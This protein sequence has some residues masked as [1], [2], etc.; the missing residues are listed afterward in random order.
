MGR[1]VDFGTQR[2]GAR[3]TLRNIEMGPQHLVPQRSANAEEA[4]AKPATTRHAIFTTRR[5]VLGGGAMML[6]GCTCGQARAD[7]EDK[8]CQQ[9]A[10]SGAIPCGLCNG[11]GLF[12]LAQ[13]LVEQSVECP[14][15]SGAGALKCTRCLGT[16][17]FNTAGLLR[18]PMVSQG[19]LRVR[20]DGSIEIL[21]C[22]AFPATRGKA[23]RGGG[24]EQDNRL[25]EELVQSAPK[26]GLVRRP[27]L[28]LLDGTSLENM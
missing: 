17:L 15:C 27:E 12:L 28:Q 3:H 8:V 25:T 20:D 19:K 18:G 14:Q 6:L 1:E 22:E 5:A 4:V 2:I 13:G 10:G 7:G 24:G 21:D 26:G 11:T 23:C 9:C 16:G